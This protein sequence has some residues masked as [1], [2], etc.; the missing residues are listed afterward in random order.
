VVVVVA[1]DSTTLVELVL[2]VTGQAFLA[3]LLAVVQ[4]RNLPLLC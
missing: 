1:T 3:K 4:V 2:V